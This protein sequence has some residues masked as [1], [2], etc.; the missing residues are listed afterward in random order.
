MGATL[1]EM[2]VKRIIETL[3]KVKVEA[4]V[5]TVADTLVVVVHQTLTKHTLTQSEGQ[6]IRQGTD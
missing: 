4:V 1:K 2:E 3:L 5:D 6:L